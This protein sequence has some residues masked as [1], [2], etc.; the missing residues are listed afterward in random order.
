MAVSVARL[1]KFNV[2]VQQLYCIETLARVDVICLDK[3]GT[4]TSGKMNM[5]EFIPDKGVKKDYVDRVLSNFSYAFKN[6]NDTLK[7]I[8]EKY[9]IKGNWEI[10]DVIEFSSSRK[11]SVATFKEEGTFFLGAPEFVL[12]EQVKKYSEILDKYSDYRTLVLAKEG[13]NTKQVLGFVIIEDEIRKT[14]PA[15]LAYFKEQGVRVKIISGDNFKTVASIAR[16]AGLT[17]VNGVDARTITEENVGEAVL[18]YDVFGR[19]IKRNK[20]SI[21]KRGNMKRIK[22]KEDE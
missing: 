14:A 18:K 8:Q 9:T 4:I 1:A 5:K 6:V 12:K 15:T 21:W 22:H 11:Y 13:K 2:L 16:R 20:D 19:V 7:A 17:D 3:T 10:K